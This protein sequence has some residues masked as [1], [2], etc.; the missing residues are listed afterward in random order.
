MKTGGGGRLR[1]MGG[2]VED[3]LLF[4]PLLFGDWVV[5]GGFEAEGLVSAG[6]G[7]V[8][9]DFGTGEVDFVGDAWTLFI[10]RGALEGAQPRRVMVF[11]GEVGGEVAVVAAGFGFGDEVDGGADGGDIAG[12]VA[13]DVFRF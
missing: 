8:V 6:A 7:L 5:V 11:E 9:E 3:G 1:I 12:V 13:D 4:E 10:R 2:P